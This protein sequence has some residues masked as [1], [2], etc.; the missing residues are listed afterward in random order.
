MNGKYWQRAWSI[1]DGCTPCSLGCDHCWSMAMGK[2]FKKWPDRVTIRPDRLDI[3]LRTRKPTVFSVWN[4]LFHEDVP[5]DFRT[6]AWLNMCITHRHTYLVLTKRAER[7][8]TFVSAWKMSDFPHIWLG[9]TVCNQSEADEKIPLLL[10]T[11]AAH[12]WVSIEPMLSE[13]DI[14]PYTHED[15]D[16]FGGLHIDAVIL[17]GESGPGARPMHPDWA[18]SVRDQCKAAGVPFF[19]KQWGTLPSFED[20]I[21]NKKPGPLEAIMMDVK[22]LL[23][24]QEHNELPWRD[25]GA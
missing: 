10:Q 18:R 12:R 22:R 17:G 19:F 4:D 21:G 25:R 24:G 11:P 7:M 6:A 16:I 23:D 20:C 2:R 15:E 3:P 13:I 14:D 8:R 9:V 5:F 1:I